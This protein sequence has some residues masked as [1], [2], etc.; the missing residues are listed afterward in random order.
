MKKV[1]MLM[2]CIMVVLASMPVMPVSAAT[3]MTVD[4]AS[5]L[6][7][8]TH[9]ASGSLY[10]I[11]ET[12]P[13]D[14][15][16][17]VAPLKPYVF[18]NPAR[19][20]SGYQQ[21]IGAA[22]PVAGRIAGTTGKVQIRLADIYPNWPYTFSNMTDWLNKVRAVIT[23]KKASG[24]TNFHGYEI[25]NE[26][27]ITWNTANGTFNNLWLQTYNTIRSNDAGAKIIGPSIATYN[28]NYMNS[29]M[30]FCKTNNCLPDIVCWHE[31]NTGVQYVSGD[32]EDYRAIESS[33]GISAR[34]I[35]INEYCD[36]TRA[37]EGQPGS[38]ARYI[39]KFERYTVESACI[40]WWFT[41]YPGRLGS[42]LATDTQK[43]AGWWFYKWYGDMSGNMVS[44][45]SPNNKGTGID[46]FACVDS[47]AKYI[48]MLM[49]GPNDGT[50]NV[51]FKNIPS[52]IGSTASVKVEKVD[53]VNKDT[54]S[55]GPATISTSNYTVSNGQITVSVT[56]MNGSSGYRIY[57]TPGS[58]SGAARYEA[59]S[60]TRNRCNV[61]SSSTCSNNQYV[62]QI[63][64]SDSYV[65]FTVNAATAKAYTMTVHYANGGTA[66]STHNVSVNG[67]TAS[68]IS[69]STT[70]G[71][72]NAPNNGALVTK[73]VS[74]N[75]GS[76]TIRFTKATNYAEIDYI[77]LN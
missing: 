73:S 27:D 13:A 30:S 36:P 60:A 39:A 41:A 64:Y 77:E 8:V 57:I 53:W 28:H 46:G 50:T 58:G 3:A 70:G 31:L 15:A 20:G 17:L 23:D 9:C 38:S 21:P 42:L 45:T 54:V 62:G 7:G 26:P 61:F 66:A 74:L 47:G 35:C 55:N 71:W 25:W 63:D 34:P 12:K 16:N 2:L 43:G 18:T 49:G 40:S 22:I 1:L 19:A 33:L 5:V 52:F 14:V 69:Y 76:N 68:S 48:S 65:Q 4:C 44:V 32:I 51:T 11:T 24:Y 59:E 6:R 72:F 56:G 67:G 10:G 37:L 29:F 75:A